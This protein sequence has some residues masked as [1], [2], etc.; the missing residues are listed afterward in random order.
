MARE[1]PVAVAVAEAVEVAEEVAELVGSEPTEEVAMAVTDMVEVE[2]R[3]RVG[4]GELVQGCCKHVDWGEVVAMGAEEPVTELEPEKEALEEMV[5]E[6]VEVAV[7]AAER[8]AAEPVAFT[9]TVWVREFWG[10]L[11]TD[12]VTEVVRVA[13]E[14]PVME[15]VRVRE[16][17][18]ERVAHMV[19][20]VCVGQWDTVTEVVPERV[21]EEEEVGQ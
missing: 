19:T 1:V 9:D 7:K 21:G 14:V 6:M 3:E 16:E 4:P 17:G 20:R 18:M 13:W 12:T 2:V 8:V 5:W 11:D 15:G 10:E